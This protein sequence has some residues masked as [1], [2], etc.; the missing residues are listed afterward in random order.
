[1][2]V[3]LG[4]VSVLGA[5]VM[6]DAHRPTPRSGIAPIL[7]RPPVRPAGVSARRPP[8][9]GHERRMLARAPRVRPVMVRRAGGGAPEQRT[10]ALDIGCG[11][12][13]VAGPADLA[14]G[15]ELL[16]TVDIGVD[17]G[18][19]ARVVHETPGGLKGLR[20]DALNAADRSHLERFVALHS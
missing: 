2:V 10:F 3:A 5:I 12:A 11:G 9:G 1:M 20:F 7:P 17:V 15:E 13:L 19:Q 18:V 14:V 4:V 8:P 6:A 16:V